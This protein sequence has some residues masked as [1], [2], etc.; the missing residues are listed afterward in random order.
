MVLS[1]VSYLSYKYGWGGKNYGNHLLIIF[2]VYFFRG[3]GDVSASAA[4]LGDPFFFG[5]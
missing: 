1:L 2:L 4:K 3:I 5:N